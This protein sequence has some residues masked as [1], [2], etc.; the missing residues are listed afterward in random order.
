MPEGQSRASYDAEPNDST[1]P[2]GWRWSGSHQRSLRD[3]HTER[4]GALTPNGAVS[5]QQPRPQDKP[6]PAISPSPRTTLHRGLAGGPTPTGLF[7]RRISYFETGSS[8]FET[9][10]CQRFA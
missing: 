2:S 10:D 5:D 6:A 9:A 4:V 7:S 8:F 3:R 1:D